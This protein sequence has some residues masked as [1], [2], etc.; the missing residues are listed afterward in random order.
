MIECGICKKTDKN[1]FCNLCIRVPY[2]KIKF[3]FSN[4]LEHALGMRE[5]IMSNSKKL[6]TEITERMKHIYYAQQR[7]TLAQRASV[8]RLTEEVNTLKKQLDISIMFDI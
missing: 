6:L 7:E 2:F 1:M 5:K 3:I 4:S 8:S